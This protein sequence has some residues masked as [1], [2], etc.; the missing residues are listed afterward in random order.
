MLVDSHCH[1]DFPEFQEDFEGVLARAREAGVGRFLSIC[2]HVERF[3]PILA[4]AER[5]P[6][7]WCTVGTHPHSADEPAERSVTID[8]LVARTRHERVVGIGETGLD[9]FYDNSPRDIQ[10]ESFRRHLRAAVEA[11][12]PVI[13]HTRDADEDTLRILKEE[14]QGGRLKGLLHCFSSSQWLAEAAVG[15]LGFLISFSGILTFKKADELRATARALPAEALL[16]ETD[17]PFLAPMPHRGKRNEP[18]F[19]A[20][21]AARLAEERG[22]SLEDLARRTTANFHRLFDRIPADGRLAA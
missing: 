12:V 22:E 8:E 9:Y 3:A 1:L 10:Q 5:E 21:T 18:A 6:D 2:T 4:L 7:I 15:E 11:G 20:H 19:V 13:V 16:V 14:S 17:A